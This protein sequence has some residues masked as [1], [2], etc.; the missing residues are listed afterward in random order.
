MTV[1]IKRLTLNEG[2]VWHASIDRMLD[3]VRPVD[4][5]DVSGR[6]EQCPVKGYNDSIFMGAIN[7]RRSRPWLRESTLGDF[8]VHA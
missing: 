7:R 6:P 8:C 5:T 2:D 4:T 3:R 1:V